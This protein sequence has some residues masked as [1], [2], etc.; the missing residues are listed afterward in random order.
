MAPVGNAVTVLTLLFNESSPL[1][2]DKPW[3]IID[4]AARAS[5]SLVA[6]GGI[7]DG[8]VRD[9]ELK[10]LAG[11]TPDNGECDKEGIAM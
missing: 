3:L 7:R 8:A 4:F 9:T 10:L 1:L 5:K 6:Q 2:S 11:D